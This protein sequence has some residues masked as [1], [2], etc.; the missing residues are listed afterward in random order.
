MEIPPAARSRTGPLGERPERLLLAEPASVSHPSWGFPQEE[1]EDRLRSASR[2]LA[3]A[4]RFP[5]GLLPWIGRAG[6]AVR[7]L[8][9]RTLAVLERSHEYGGT[10]TMLRVHGLARD[11]LTLDVRLELDVMGIDAM[12]PTASA[13]ECAREL[14]GLA[15][16]AFAAAMRGPGPDAL[17]AGL[18]ATLASHLA[19]EGSTAPLGWMLPTPFSPPASYLGGSDP[20]AADRPERDGP[21][22]P[23]AVSIE[24][25][26]GFADPWR[27]SV[28]IRPAYVDRKDGED[29]VA[30]LRDVATLAR[31]ELDVRRERG[32]QGP[33]P[34]RSDGDRRETT[35]QDELGPS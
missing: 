15:L 8:D 5:W 34:D 2:L 12:A 6:R 29:V 26:R 24:I 16:R 21:E 19:R 30:A 4:G 28:V 11:R 13:D 3:G 27:M 14:V 23:H 31:L 18:S 9:F 35:S 33:V 32:R 22:L 7:A 1:I 20:L 25:T 17:R 10:S